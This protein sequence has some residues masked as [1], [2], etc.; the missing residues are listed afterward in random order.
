VG[1][2]NCTCLAEDMSKIF[3]IYWD[4]G[5]P[6]AVIP[7][8]WPADLSTRY[9][10]SNPL[11][12]AFNDSTSY[13]FLASSPPE[14]CAD[15]RTSDIDAI[16]HVIN[17]SKKFVWVAVMDYY[18]ATLYTDVVMF[19]PVIDDAL[20]KAAIERQVEVKILA[21]HWNHTRE[22]MP[23]FLKSLSVLNNSYA[24]ISIEVKLFVVPSFTIEQ[25]LI[26]FARVNHNKYMVTD[27][28][29]YIGTS[30]WSADYFVNTGG[31]GLV[32]NQ[33]QTN[34]PNST[35]PVKDALQGIFTR[36]WN[37]EYAKPLSSF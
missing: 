6:G 35:Q 31:I 37:S 23:Y 13:T 3:Q 7:P 25:A 20:K 33:T 11:K 17:S 2:Y 4:L 22:S 1:I 5:K 30:N 24:S 21:S 9:N 8:H 15:G 18:P 10:D 14:L 34:D 32:V 26:P 19:W 16:L 29:A 28:A 12:L 27:N 36:D